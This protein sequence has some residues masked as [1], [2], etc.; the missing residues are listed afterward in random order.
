MTESVCEARMRLAFIALHHPL[1]Q[2]SPE[3]FPISQII[4][5]GELLINYP[6]QVDTIF[7]PKHRLSTTE[8]FGD[9]FERD[10]I[11]PNL[12]PDLKRAFIEDMVIHQDEWRESFNL[13][14]ED[15]RPLEQSLYDV[16]AFRLQTPTT[17]PMF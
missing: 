12:H 10:N 6:K 8:I 5:D 2:M 3:H 14:R 11:K 13:G 17:S 9:L 1:D 16:I 15:L 4:I 7:D